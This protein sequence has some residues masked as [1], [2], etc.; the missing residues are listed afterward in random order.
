MLSSSIPPK[1]LK[2]K[3]KVLK[4]F[5]NGHLEALEIA[6]MCLFVFPKRETGHN[7]WSLQSEEGIKV[8]I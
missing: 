5:I 4:A 2:T 1:T 6:H 8:S 7:C 3:M